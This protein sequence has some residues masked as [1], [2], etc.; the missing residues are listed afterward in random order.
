M[1]AEL[2]EFFHL[3]LAETITETDVKELECNK[4][5]AAK[6]RK[7]MPKML[8]NCRELTQRKSYSL[9]LRI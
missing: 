7:L 6:F 3:T 5:K 2:H 1:I 4:E 9:Q 8:N